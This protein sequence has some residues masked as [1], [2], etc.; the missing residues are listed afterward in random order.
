MDLIVK[1]KSRDQGADSIIGRKNTAGESA[2]RS[3]RQCQNIYQ[4]QLVAVRQ[5]LGLDLHPKRPC[6]WRSITRV[7]TGEIKSCLPG[8]VKML[9]ALSF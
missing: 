7:F 6:H 2:H 5:I 9:F 1:K 4:Q 8:Q 3:V